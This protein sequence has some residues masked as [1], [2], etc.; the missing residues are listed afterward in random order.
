MSVTRLPPVV[1]SGEASPRTH[2]RRKAEACAPY[3]SETETDVLRAYSRVMLPDPCNG[4][5]RLGERL[6]GIDKSCYSS[7]IT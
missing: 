2:T 4:E 6:G 7:V 1:A 3:A 5:G